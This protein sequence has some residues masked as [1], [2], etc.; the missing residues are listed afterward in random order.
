LLIGA[1]LLITSYARIGGASPGFNPHQVLS[2]RAAL[3]ASRY[4]NP[5]AVAAFYNQLDQR[6]RALPGIESVSTSYL[7]PLTGNSLGW[8]PT[9]IDGYVPRNAQDVIISNVGFVGPE[10]FRVLGIPLIK[11]RCFDEQDKK[12]SQEVAI[13]DAN[14]AA[15]FWPDQDPIGKRVQR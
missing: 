7:L 5:G 1:G 14:L 11:G 10:Y 9:L 3:P 4:P 6:V 15:R 8:E 13:V 2:L 12:G